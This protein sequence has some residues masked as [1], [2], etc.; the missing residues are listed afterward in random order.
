[1]CCEVE[2][3]IRVVRWSAFCCSDWCRERK[4]NHLPPA[5]NASHI[6]RSRNIWH[7][8]LCRSHGTTSIPAT[9]IRRASSCCKLCMGCMCGPPKPM[10]VRATRSWV[11][12][13]VF[14]KKRKPGFETVGSP[15]VTPPAS[16]RWEADVREADVREVWMKQPSKKTAS[17][18]EP[19]LTVATTIFFWSRLARC[20]E[21]RCV[22]WGGHLPLETFRLIPAV[23]ATIAQIAVF[24][25]ELV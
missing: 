6:N 5:S 7:R 19:I 21:N 14:T 16:G 2:S 3:T 13:Y 8:L 10:S 23:R 11:F 12:L 9:F 17:E 18:D 15:K 1:M 25:V 24:V 20:R 4:A 22:W